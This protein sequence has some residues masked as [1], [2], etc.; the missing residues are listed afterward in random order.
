MTELRRS[1]V[2]FADLERALTELGPRIA[3]PPTPDIASTISADIAAQPAR[4][5]ISWRLP[6]RL[7]PR[8]LAFAFLMMLMIAGAAVTVSPGLRTSI[9]KRIGVHGI[10]IIFVEETPTPQASPVGTT[11]LLGELTTFDAAQARVDYVIQ[12]PAEL[13]PPD[14]LYFRRLSSG[15]MVSLLYRSRPG[16]PETLETGV[17]A[18]L[19]QF[20][21]ETDAADIAKRVSVGMAYVTEVSVNGAAG[22]WVTGQS[23]LVIDQDPSAG[24]QET[25]GRPSGNVLIW[26]RD[27]MT[28]RLESALGRA[29]A[30]RI[31]ESLQGDQSR[32]VS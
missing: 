2:H 14:E 31:A 7:Q 4:R 25:V 3:F 12:M 21:A 30:I 18:L 20:P 10:E 1:H 22:Y 17:G 32:D 26:E 19:M 27:G 8:R 6:A 29:D 28:Y 9:A 16:L 11:L 5:H 24:W 23:E 15:M 13:G